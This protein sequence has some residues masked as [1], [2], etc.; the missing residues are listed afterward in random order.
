LR[1]LKG[2]V[3]KGR[4]LLQPIPLLTVD[5]EPCFASKNAEDQYYDRIWFSRIQSIRCQLPP[6]E[7]A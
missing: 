2:A 3:N 1:W 7:A 4:P 6:W 5:P